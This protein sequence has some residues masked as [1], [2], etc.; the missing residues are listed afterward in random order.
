MHAA[1]RPDAFSAF[2]LKGAAILW[3][4]VAV[5]GQGVFAYYIAVFYGGAALA[6]D[7]EAW[8]RR[9]INGIIEG[10]PVGNASLIIHLA[11]AFVITV[12]GP[13]Q[14]VPA[15]RSAVPVVH[16]WI[17]RTYIV[18]AVVISLGALHIVLDRGILGR[19]NEI[20]ISFNAV[21]LLAA[22]LLTI[23]AAM[24]RRFD[25][26]RRWALRT[27]MLASGVWFFRLGIGLWALLTQG[28]MHGMT[29][30][31]SGWFDVTLSFACYLLPLAVLEAYFRVQEHGRSAANWAMSAVLGLAALATAAGTF[32]AARIFWLPNL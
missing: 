26:H 13:L 29:R 17:G 25:A 30:Q 2:V 9:L 10:D 32:M 3:F 21:L 20:A 19:W 4:L 11:L 28:E 18:T 7:W 23:R 16:R 1:D 27:F 14:F 15:I 8:S 12:L 5:A 22:A 6:D 24:T 31:L